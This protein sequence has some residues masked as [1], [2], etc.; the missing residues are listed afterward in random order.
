MFPAIECTDEVV[1][2]RP[3]E[4]GHMLVQVVSTNDM[5]NLM[6]IPIPDVT[7][8]I[9]LLRDAL[10]NCIQWPKKG[11]QLDTDEVKSINTILFF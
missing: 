4:P 8:D 3:L 2:G 5:Y 9:V 1:Q 6:P 11:I 10:T 7:N